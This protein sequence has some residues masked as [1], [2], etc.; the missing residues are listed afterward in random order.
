MP[1][2]F[3]LMTHASV[4]RDKALPFFLSKGQTMQFNVNRIIEAVIIAGVISMVTMLVG[5]PVIK[6]EMKANQQITLEKISVL[7]KQVERQDRKITKIYDD[8]YAPVF[9]QRAK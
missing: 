8:T 2:F 3:Y 7:Q 5:I 4:Q 1:P 6:Q 9:R